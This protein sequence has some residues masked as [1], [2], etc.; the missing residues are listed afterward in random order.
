MAIVADR[1]LG[2]VPPY[3][4]AQHARYRARLDAA[5]GEHDEVEAGFTTTEDI[6]AE[7]G[8]PYWLAR[9]RLDH[10]VWLTERGQPDS[11]ALLAEQAAEVFAQLGAAPAL[12][13]ARRLVPAAAP[14]PL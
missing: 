5:R 8:Y 13:Q 10:A 4:R 11:A 7:L 1:P 12:T 6:L 14:T 9:T 2:H 3:L